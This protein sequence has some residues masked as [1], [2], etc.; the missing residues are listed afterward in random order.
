MR[1]VVCM[2]Y[3]CVFSRSFEADFFFFL[4][5]LRFR[6]ARGSLKANKMLALFFPV[7][8]YRGNAK[9]TTTA[10]ARE[11]NSHPCG[12]P[13]SVHVFSH[14]SLWAKI[15]YVFVVSGILSQALCNCW[16]DSN[17]PYHHFEP[18]PIFFIK[19]V[20]VRPLSALI[21]LN[22]LDQPQLGLP[23]T[24]MGPEAPFQLSPGLSVP[25]WA[26][27]E[28]CCSP[29]CPCLCPHF[30]FTMGFVDPDLNL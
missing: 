10:W 16:I 17:I 23:P 5:Q 1:Y 20:Y 3:V 19:F 2:L 30:C 18:P 24:P 15:K 12:E 4:P 9:T 6:W 28:E 22:G 25:G 11:C 27:S 14:T 29:A 7:C 26:V 21:S 8:F 13:S